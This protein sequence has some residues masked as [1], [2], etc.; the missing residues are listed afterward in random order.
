MYIEQSSY[1]LAGTNSKQHLNRRRTRLRSEAPTSVSIV[2]KLF[3]VE[4]STDRSEKVSN[5]NKRV[6]KFMHTVSY[7]SHS[8]TVT[9][10][11]EWVSRRRGQRLRI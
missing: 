8:L 3:I 5:H 2:V 9:V 4:E 1:G 6:I 10:I 11:Y 7:E